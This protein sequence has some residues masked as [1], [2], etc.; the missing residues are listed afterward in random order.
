M[1][2]QLARIESESLVDRVYRQ[3]RRLILEGRL[4]P[5]ERL[6]QEVLARDLGIS[7]T[8]LREALNRLASEG[9]IEFRPHRSAVVAEYSERD[10]TA[11]YEARLVLEPAAARLAALR[12]DP[13]TLKA[14]RAAL[15]AAER[16]GGDVERLFAANRAFHTALVAGAGNPHLTRFVESL[17]GG[18]I[19]PVFYARQA[20]LPG[21][22][23]R[24]AADHASIAELIGRGA[25]DEAAEAVRNH[26]ERALEHLLADG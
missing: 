7:R 25:A 5:G 26:L 17:W 22:Q 2:V 12:R 8:P 14:L 3:L 19:A 10:I 6:R 18:R 4:A 24:D 9:L 11:D 1:S 16:A 21:Q 20:R 15:R 13:E 23:A